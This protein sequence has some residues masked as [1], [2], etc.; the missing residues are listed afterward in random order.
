MMMDVMLAN[1][2]DCERG[3]IY[4]HQMFVEI[5]GRLLKSNFY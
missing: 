2:D 1:V 5:E 3:K 4:S